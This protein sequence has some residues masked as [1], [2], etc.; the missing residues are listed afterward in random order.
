MIPQISDKKPLIR[1]CVCI[2]IPNS[3]EKRAENN[4]HSKQ[5]SDLRDCY[6]KQGENAVVVRIKENAC[7]ICVRHFNRI[8]DYLT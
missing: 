2:R 4:E 7:R 3:P 5:C 6:A 8:F 1:F